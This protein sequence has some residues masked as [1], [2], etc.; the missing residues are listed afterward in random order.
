MVR[1][2][3]YKDYLVF[4]M[5]ERYDSELANSYKTEISK[6][7][8]AGQKKII[9]DFTETKIINSPEIGLLI[10]VFRTLKEKN[11]DLI[12]VGLSENLQ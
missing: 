9:F 4:N 12:I 6:M 8:S 7:I 5:P 2:S 3:K 11:G 1:Q 10:S